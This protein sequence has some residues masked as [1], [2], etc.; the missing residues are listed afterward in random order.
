M[1]NKILI[2][3]L[4]VM[5]A[6]F[7][8]SSQALA[9]EIP[10]YPTCANPQGVVVASYPDGTT[11]GIVGDSTQ[12]TGKDIVYELNANSLQQCFCSIDGQGIQ[13]NW[14]KISSLDPE[15][16]QTL[17]NAGWIYVPNGALW[18]LQETPYLAQNSNYSCLGN[19]PTVTPTQ[20]SNGGSDGRSD[21]RSDGLGCGNHD[22]SGNK[23]TSSQGQVLG[24][25][26]SVFASTKGSVLGLA[27]TGGKYTPY[28]LVIAG[29]TI[30][31]FGILLNRKTSHK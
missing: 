28:M 18:G 29:M 24:A 30:I 7:F 5:F 14:W 1:K 8:G 11:H 26:T 31:L 12:Y 17:R 3:V 16:I 2:T 19:N 4:S 9:D 25:S 20:T 15:Q 10:N 13:T 6:L 22:C 27:S 21:G 23:M